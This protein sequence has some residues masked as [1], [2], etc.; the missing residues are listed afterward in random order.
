LSTIWYSKQKT[1][2]QKLD[3]FASSGNKVVRLLL[4]GAL[5]KGC[6]HSLAKMCQLTGFCM[7]LVSG[8]VDWRYWKI[9]SKNCCSNSKDLELKQENKLKVM[10]SNQS[11]SQP[12]NRFGRNS[13]LI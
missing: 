2:F 5:Y 9:F 8:F 10:P 12:T 13:E 3:F 1:V 4:S 6:S 7:F 11:K